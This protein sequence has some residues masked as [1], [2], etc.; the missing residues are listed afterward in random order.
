MNT[1][2][3]EES[4]ENFSNPERGFFVPFDPIGSDGKNLVYPLKLSELE[5]TKNQNITLIRRYYLLLDFRD[6]PLSQSFL[7][8]IANDF[9]TARNAGVKLIIGFAYNW[10]GGGS[11]ASQDRILSH[12]DQLEPLFKINYD[13]IAYMEAGFIGFWGEWNRSTYS[14][15]SNNNSRREILF[16][17][18]SILPPERMVALRY[19]HHKRDIF[20]NQNPLQ[21]E[22]AFNGTY[23]AR[24]GA[25]NNCFLASIDDWGT[26]NHTDPYIVEQQKIFLN[27][28]N[29]YV[30]QGGE[31][32]AVSEYDD[33]PNAL[34][35]L[36]RMRWSALN[37]GVYD[38]AKILKDWENQGCIAEIKRR[39]GYRLRLLKSTSPSKVKPLGELSIN[40]EI[41][42]DGWASPYNPRKLEVILRN[43]KTLK[44]Y[45][46]VVNEEP[47]MWLSGATKLVNVIGGIPANIPEG[48]YE[49]LLNLPDPM[50]KLYNRPEYSIRLANQKVWEPSTG[51]NSLLSKV[52]IDAN[53]KNITYSGQGFYQPR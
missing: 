12:L 13:V 15:D 1:I 38:G 49:I 9:T 20:N 46:L 24:T 40:F 52:F 4:K 26:Y 6:K 47:R 53:A 44:E 36:A 50:P 16:K 30:V 8:M 41:T 51:Y 7:D 28:D 22:E 25:I 43:N 45:Y 29:Q 10:Q 23:R 21:S 11:D 34:N 5:K 19:A 2:I 3:Y 35:Q 32:C 27:Q 42:N 18:L 33:C 48:E 17:I 37:I 39:L 14:L 31:V